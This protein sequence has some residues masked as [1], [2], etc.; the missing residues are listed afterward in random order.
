MADVTLNLNFDGIKKLVAESVDD[1]MY[2]GARHLAGAVDRNLAARGGNSKMRRRTW[3]ASRTRRMGRPPKRINKL[4]PGQAAVGNSSPLAH[5]YEFGAA[6]HSVAPKRKETMVIN[7]RHVKGEHTHPG[8]AAR[9]F[10]RPA[11]DEERQKIGEVITNHLRQSLEHGR[12]LTV[13]EMMAAD[14]KRK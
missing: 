12:L 9:P 13:Q 11:F 14:R 4:Q 2:A 6:P 7:G 8:M 5:L 1:A 3:A 10:L